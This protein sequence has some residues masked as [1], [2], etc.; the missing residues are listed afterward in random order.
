MIE[1]V[2]GWRPLLLL[3]FPGRN[4]D[5]FRALGG[6]AAHGDAVCR[7]DESG[8]VEGVLVVRWGEHAAYDAVSIGG[9]ERVKMI[10]AHV[11]LD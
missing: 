10:P 6:G 5:K 11:E 1:Y 9:A 3:R 2:P 7:G 4:S 8:L